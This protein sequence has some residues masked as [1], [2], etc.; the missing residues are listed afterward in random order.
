MAKGLLKELEADVVRNAI[1]DTGIRIDGRDTKTVRPIAAEVHFL[2]RAHGS[3]LFTRGETQTIATFG[4]GLNDAL[5]LCFTVAQNLSNPICSIFQGVR[6]ATTGAIGETSG[7]R[8]PNVLSANIATLKTSGIDVAADYSL[9]VDFS[10]TGSGS[11]KFAFSFLGTY[12]DKFRSTAVA[13]IPEREVIGEGSVPQIP[14]TNPLPKWKHNARLTLSDGPA[15]LSLRWRHFGPV[16]DRR[17]EN[18][19]VGLVRTPQ[20]AALFP[21][22]RIAPADYFD[23]SAGFEATK[24]LQINS[25]VNNLLNEKPTILGSLQEQANTFPGTYDVLGRDF[26]VGARLQF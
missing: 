10:I 11:S 13:S 23:L 2:P 6:N 22:A 26:F 25:G 4:G 21:N 16:K 3:A 1:L 5:Q 17:L 19:F 9:P 24:T 7:G 15:L 14:T 20:D 8:N 18:T 12:L